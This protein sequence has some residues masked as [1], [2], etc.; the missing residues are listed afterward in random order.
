MVSDIEDCEYD[1]ELEAI[2][3]KIKGMKARRV[4]LQF[5]DGLKTRSKNVADALNKETC[6]E[7][8]IWAQTNFGACDIPAGLE[9]LKIDLVVAFGH[10]PFHKQPEGW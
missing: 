5:P 8:L 10:S 7:V 2:I 4:L 3:K 9:N 6:A 1:L